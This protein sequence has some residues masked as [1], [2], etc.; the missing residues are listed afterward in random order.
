MEKY[1]K[2]LIL[3]TVKSTAFVLIF[4]L[5]WIIFA[6]PVLSGILPPGTVGANEEI[7]GLRWGIVTGFF[8]TMI[9]YTIR[10]IYLL[11]HP[12]KLEKNYISSNDERQKL[13]NEKTGST[14]S[15]TVMA[16][17]VAGVMISGNYNVVVCKTLLFVILGMIVVY[18]GCSIYYRHKY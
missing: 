17:L 14:T 6:T 11:R 10:N 1:K 13:I 18:A 3:C 4:I 16:L 12:A 7:Q 2:Q 8:T 5:L 15:I 9:F